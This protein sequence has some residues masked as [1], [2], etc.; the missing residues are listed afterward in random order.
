MTNKF[1][2]LLVIPSL[3]MAFSSFAEETSP[4]AD[5]VSIS[6]EKQLVQV[7]DNIGIFEN[8]VEIIHGNRQIRADRLE[9]HKREDLGDNKQ[10][11]VATG[12][13]AYFEEKLTD[14]TIMS[15]SANEVRYDVEQRLL[16]LIGHAQVTQDG[17]KINAKSITYDMDQQLISAERGEDSNDRVHT[18]LVPVDSKE[19]KSKGQP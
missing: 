19:T 17:Q 9:V 1:A 18:I 11:L 6:A 2:H 10:L 3:F 16:T 12:E 15:A 14:G 8:N 7:K 13:P 5:Q 4:P